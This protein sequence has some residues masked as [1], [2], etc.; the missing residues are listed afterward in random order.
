MQA[1]TLQGLVSLAGVQY[2]LAT[3]LAVEAAI[4]HNFVWH[5]RWTWAD[6]RTASRAAGLKKTMSH[7]RLARFVRFNGA[8]ALVSIGGNVVLMALLVGVWG[9]PLLVGMALAVAAT[10]VVNFA[11][12]DRLVFRR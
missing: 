2:P 8:T 11:C 6:R 9:L 4:V 3:A 7:A 10:S 5:E 1:L 12:A